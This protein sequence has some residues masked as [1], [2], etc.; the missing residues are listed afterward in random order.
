M[1][2]RSAGWIAGSVLIGAALLA[3]A[4]VLANEASQDMPIS[5]DQ[6]K[7]GTE[8]QCKDVGITEGQVYWHILQNG[9]SAAIQSGNLTATFKDAGVI[10]PVA[11]YEKNGSTLH[12]GII[13]GEDTV[14]A[15][16]TD[17]QSDGQ[18][19]VSHVCYIVPQPTPDPTPDPSESVDPPPPPPTVSFEAETGTPKVTPPPTD[20]PG[21]S[22][23]SG[24]GWRFVLMALGGLAAVALVVTP[25]RRRSR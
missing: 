21:S 23:G 1:R 12:W 7:P 13:T 25:A 3:P 22:T 24:S 11:S 19:V 15:L 20:M 5:W 2:I 6:A 8:D 18:L 4:A 9:V 16:S 17:V 14:Q 10:G